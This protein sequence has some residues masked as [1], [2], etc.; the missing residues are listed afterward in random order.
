MS[1][2]RDRLQRA[3]LARVAG[4]T[5]LLAAGVAG[6]YGFSGGGGLPSHIR[7]GYV[8]PVGNESPRFGLSEALT[9]RL[10]QAA[11]GRLG[12]RLAA[13]TDADAIIRATVRQYNDDAV[14]F[15]AQEGVGADVFLRRVTIGA[16][17]EIYDAIEDQVLWQG[18]AVTGVGE[19]DPE[20][21][22]EEVGLELALENLVQKVVDGAQSQW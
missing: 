2:A 10:L 17:V 12:L 11:R 9:E 16:R 8:E 6:C 22:T 19:Y 20:T 14:S 1:D 21:E 3:G 15:Q 5:L 13:E 18:A 7:T 4:A